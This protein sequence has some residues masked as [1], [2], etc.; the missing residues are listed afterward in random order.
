MTVLAFEVLFLDSLDWTLQD[1]LKVSIGNYLICLGQIPA[2]WQFLLQNG[3]SRNTEGQNC[4]HLLIEVLIASAIL[5]SAIQCQG[6]FFLVL[7]LHSKEPHGT[8][9]F[10]L[11]LLALIQMIILSLLPLLFPF[12]GP[13]DPLR[14]QRLSWCTHHSYAS[15]SYVVF[16]WGW[17]HPDK[18]FPLLKCLLV[19][20]PFEKDCW[21]VVCP[22]C[23]LS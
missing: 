7:L 11:F 16:Y 5:F 17:K 9:I 15:H 10:S 13:L 21:K 2:F 3:L 8:P 1:S 6:S 22:H 18:I 20:Y 23:V 19:L 4:H 12:L 14:L